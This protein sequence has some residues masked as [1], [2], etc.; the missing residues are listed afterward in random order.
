MLV[1]L[2]PFCLSL[3]SYSTIFHDW[4]IM[5]CWSLTALLSK[6]IS[7]S[8]SAATISADTT[9]WWRCSHGILNGKFF[10]VVHEGGVVIAAHYVCFINV[11]WVQVTMW[12]KVLFYFCCTTFLQTILHHFLI[13]WAGNAEWLALGEAFICSCCTCHWWVDKNFA[14]ISQLLL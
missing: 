9:S 12:A 6:D 7:S 4:A 2:N 5:S 10:F 1:G 11:S 8:L 3:S 13:C 14:D